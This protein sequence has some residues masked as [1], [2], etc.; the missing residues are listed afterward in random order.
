MSERTAP[1][2]A[3][4]ASARRRRG[5]TLVELL[6]VVIILGVLAAIVIPQF[7]ETSAA[8]K[9]SSLV[10]NLQTVRQAISLYRVQHNEIYPGQANF[11]QLVTQLSTGTHADGSAGGSYGPYLRT[12][13]PLNPFT[14]PPS[15]SGTNVAVMPS[16]PSGS[17]AYLYN[18]ATG[19][20]RANVTGQAP[21]G[22][23]FW[24]L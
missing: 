5:F 11:A 23:D 12:G 4:L 17:E 16:G 1:A 10:A 24:D 22:T 7:G 9:E 19:E 14:S 18:P 3:P 2:P 8:A 21:S 20:I 15:A 6:I 13:F